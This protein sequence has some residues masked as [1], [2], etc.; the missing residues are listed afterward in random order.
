MWLLFNIF[1][2]SP[3]N[4]KNQTDFYSRLQVLQAEDFCLQELS[5]LAACPWLSLLT[6]W[7]CDR[8][9]QELFWAQKSSLMSLAFHS[10]MAFFFLFH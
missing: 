9:W 1:N 5:T 10:G 6:E 4:Y 2:T 7:G 3:Q 8:E